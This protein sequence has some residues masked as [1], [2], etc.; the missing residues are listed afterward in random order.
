MVKAGFEVM[1]GKAAV[2][3]ITV[4]FLVDGMLLVQP[5]TYSYVPT[6]RMFIDAGFVSRRMLL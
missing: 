2:K 6:E 1:L 5:L 4:S 3:S